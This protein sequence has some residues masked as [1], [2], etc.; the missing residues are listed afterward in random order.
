MDS[1]KRTM[2]EQHFYETCEDVQLTQSERI[3]C[4]TT[5]K[6]FEK[7]ENIFDEVDEKNYENLLFLLKVSKKISDWLVDENESTITFKKKKEILFHMISEEGISLMIICFY[8]YVGKFTNEIEGFIYL[9]K[10]NKLNSKFKSSLLRYLKFFSNLLNLSSIPRIMNFGIKNLKIKKK[11]NEFK[12]MKPILF[13]YQNEYLKH[14]LNLNQIE[15]KD[16]IELKPSQLNEYLNLDSGDFQIELYFTDRNEI[17]KI[18]RF[19]Y[20][21]IF[22]NQK[23]ELNILNNQ[24]DQLDQNTQILNLYLNFSQLNTQSKDIEDYKNNLLFYLNSSIIFKKNNL[25]DYQLNKKRKLEINKQSTLTI[26]DSSPIKKIKPNIPILK[27]E[28]EKTTHSLVKVSSKTKEIFSTKDSKISITSIPQEEQQIP[29]QQPIQTSIPPSISIPISTSITPLIPV[30]PPPLPPPPSSPPKYLK[31]ETKRSKKKV[32]WKP[33]K[34]INK[35]SIWNG[36]ENEDFDNLKSNFELI[37]KEEKMKKGIKMKEIPTNDIQTNLVLS[38]NRIRN[39]EILLK[40]FRYLSSSKED[41]IE[42]ISNLNDKNIHSFENFEALKK[43]KPTNE[44]V[45]KFRKE[46]GENI[47]INND[48]EYFLF[49][50]SKI[51]KFEQKF[52]FL[53]I[54]FILKEND[55]FLKLEGKI[56]NQMNLFKDIKNSKKLKKIFELILSSG[57]I[58]NTTNN[59]KLVKG[60]KLDFLNQLKNIKLNQTFNFLDFII[61]KSENNNFDDFFLEFENNQSSIIFIFEINNEILKYEEYIQFFNKELKT[62]NEYESNVIKILESFKIILIEKYTILKNLLNQLNEIYL[63]DILNYFSED[64]CSDEEFLKILFNFIREFKISKKLGKYK[65]LKKYLSNE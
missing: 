64:D 43:I 39:I 23:F 53:E 57:N 59:N 55:S 32:H 27:F 46:E 10:K 26:T 14:T 63:N 11:K 21:T 48:I 49:Q 12:I 28:N 24:F 35:E 1:I 54:I 13:I 15:E 6:I 38:L 34:I 3:L 33:I 56:K 42:I 44:E 61:F 41:L 25:I 20:S 29:P 40:Q 30:G 31:N 37:K 47:K 65:R 52:K 18:F 2:I 62:Q 8:L 60:F 4:I 19:T 9:K 58:L 50:I 7:T 17:K 5:S 22:I 45:L 16:F 51:N 36:N